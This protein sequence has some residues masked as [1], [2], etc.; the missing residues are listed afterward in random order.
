MS[1]YGAIR[2]FD[3]IDESLK[4]HDQWIFWAAKKVWCGNG[5]DRVIKM[6]YIAMCPLFSA[7]TNKLNTWRPFETARAMFVHSHE[8][9]AE[10][11][12]QAG[13]PDSFGLGFV[14]TEVDG[15]VGVDLDNVFDPDTE[16]LL[17][18]AEDIVMRLDSYTEYSPSKTGLRIFVKGD[19]PELG[20]KIGNHDTG[21]IEIYR[22][23]RYLTVTGDIY[24]G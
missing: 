14:L 12:K 9:L 7:S 20:R 6:P 23:G 1:I 18:W 3:A 2:S 24:R 15:L 8:R 22:S 11:A 17:P 13:A 21:A 16:K 10:V 19:I 5:D 4:A